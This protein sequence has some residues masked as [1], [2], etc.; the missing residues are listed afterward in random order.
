MADG[1]LVVETDMTDIGTG[2]Y[3]ILAQTAAETMGLPLEAVRVELGDR[4]SAVTGGPYAMHLDLGGAG[5]QV[6]FESTGEKRCHVA[7]VG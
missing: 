4:Q 1:R 6:A 7:T 3:T 2:S 5:D